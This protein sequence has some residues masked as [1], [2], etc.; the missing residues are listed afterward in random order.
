MFSVFTF[1]TKCMLFLLAYI[2][3]NRL[4][5]AIL[6]PATRGAIEIFWLHFWGAV[7]LSINAKQKWHSQRAEQKVDVENRSFNEELTDKYA[8][9]MPMFSN[10]EPVCL[11]CNETVAVE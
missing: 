10:P 9:I 11:I 7:M 4:L 8:F 1:F 6:Q 2:S 5:T 3:V